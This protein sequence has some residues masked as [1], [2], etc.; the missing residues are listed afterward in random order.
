[1]TLKKTLLTTILA[2]CAVFGFA[3]EDG[4]VAAI[5]SKLI[6]VNGG[7]FKMGSS[8][9]EKNETPVHD[10]TVD[11]FYMLSTE[12]TQ[13]EYKTVI[14]KNFSANRGDD[15]PVEEVSW[16]DAVIFCNKLSM[17]EGLFPCYSLSGQT[18][19][20]K[21]GSVPRMADS[22]ELKAY[23]NTIK[24]DFKA[25]GYRLPTEAEWEFAATEG[26][27]KS[28][29]YAGS[30][31]L[32]KVG[33]FASNAELSTK[34]VGLKKANALGFYDMNGNV[35]EW[36]QNWYGKYGSDKDYKTGLKMRR[37]GSVNSREVFCRNANR[38]S[39]TPELRG[40]DLGFRIVRNTF[41]LTGE[42]EIEADTEEE[43]DFSDVDNSSEFDVDE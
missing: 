15:L 26:G 35:W 27:T 30:A 1:M 13:K 3:D 5:N 23:W 43:I 20:D 8:D 18:D 29:S 16:Y 11:S 22:D 34:A 2:G 14:G 4:I 9:N 38:A 41:E 37:G 28:T 42:E 32:D 21:W 39:S 12:V 19:P 25:N 40:V 6:L 33:W 31:D 24:C 36:C 17:E 10:E 7:T